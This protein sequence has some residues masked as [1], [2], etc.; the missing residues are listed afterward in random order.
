VGRP[1]G[2]GSAST[3]IRVA[4]HSGD[5]LR[6]EALSAYLETL[7]DL[8]VVGRVADWE[9]MVPLCELQRPDVVLVD[10]G[11][12]PI[13]AIR[14]LR[15]LRDRFP[16]VRM[17]LGYESLSAPE[18]AEANESGVTAVVPYAHGLRGV[19]SVLRTP[20][21]GVPPGS[22]NG[23]GLT[24]RQREILLLVA[25]GHHVTEIAA[26]LG[27]SP[28]TVE[29]H[30]RRIYAK[31]NATSAAQ[32]VARAAALGVINN[33]QPPA[34]A[35][36]PPVEGEVGR[37]VLAV[38]VGDPSAELERV[39]VTLIARQLPVVR[40]HCPRP[41]PQVHW[42]RWHRGRVV[43]VL[44]N[45][46]AEHW[47]V[48]ATIGRPAVVVRGGSADHAA[49]AEALSQG[50][51]AVIHADRI[52]DEL[53]QVLDLAAEGYLVLDPGTTRPFID[54]ACARFADIPTMQPALTAREQDILRSIGRN[55][56]VRQTARALGI[57]VKTVENAQGHLFRKLGVHNRA[58]ALATAFSLGLL[59]PSH[60]GS[61]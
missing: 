34:P 46:S 29:N 50:A 15:E 51:L 58:A 27:I 16:A 61:E 39:M 36:P 59:E 21:L 42:L 26:L 12:H 11:Q 14:I 1:L 19:L 35:S 60:G 13:R 24:A 56:T 32:A 38:V 52:E 40:E 30:K 33:P 7:P 37:P 6:R 25:S 47:P 49:T 41:V 4:V 45:P 48:G 17:V 28:G 10:A 9:S 5:R 22:W 8:S 20:P 3:T 53:V 2:R 54:A 23:I 43:R 31:L 55:H 44:V 57:A 18:L